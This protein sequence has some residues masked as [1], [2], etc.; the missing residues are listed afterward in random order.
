KRLEETPWFLKAMLLALPLPYVACTL[1]WT[2]TEVGR[3]PW[4]VY[5]V[6][7]TSEAA[8]PIDPGQVAVSLVAFVLVYGLL[9]VL[10]FGLMAKAAKAG[11]EGD[12]PAEQGGN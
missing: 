10:G 9:G 2:V 1:G 8:S 6:M 5:N 3:Q 11:P 4:I 12:D 7:R